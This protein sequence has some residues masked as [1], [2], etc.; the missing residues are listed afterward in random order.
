MNLKVAQGNQK[1]RDSISHTTVPISGTRFTI[2][3]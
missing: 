3:V 2:R 1:L